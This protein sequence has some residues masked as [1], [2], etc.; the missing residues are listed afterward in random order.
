MDKYNNKDIHRAIK[1]VFDENPE[2]KYDEEKHFS[3][4]IDVLNASVNQKS[5][6]DYGFARSVVYNT[7]KPE[8][9]ELMKSHCSRK[10]A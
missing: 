3:L 4:Y 7:L 8:I 9:A 1:D 10:E 5:D 2:L 6:N